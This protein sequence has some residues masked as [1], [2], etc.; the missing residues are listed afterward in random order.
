MNLIA[1]VEL[2]LVLLGLVTVIAELQMIRRH[3]IAKE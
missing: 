2:P 3:L 1:Y